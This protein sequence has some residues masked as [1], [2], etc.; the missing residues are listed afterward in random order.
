[1][2]YRDVR[3]V[4]EGAIGTRDWPNW[5][6]LVA[7]RVAMAPAVLHAVDD[8]LGRYRHCLVTGGE[9]RGKT[10]L[11]RYVG[12]RALT[13]FERPTY[14]ISV[15][16][17]TED[18]LAQLRDAIHELDDAQAAPLWIA[19]DLQDCDEP[20]ALARLVSAAC[21]TRHSLFLYTC[22]AAGKTSPLGHLDFVIEGRPVDHKQLDVQL[23]PDSTFI[24]SAVRHHWTSV[25]RTELVEPTQADADWVFSR[26]GGNLRAVSAHLDAWEHGRLA[27]VDE[28]AVL[29]R[30]YALRL[31]TLAAPARLQLVQM[32]AV[33]QFGVPVNGDL[34]GSAAQTDALVCD[35]LLVPT[36]LPRY[37][38][39][40]H[41]TDAALDCRAWAA[42]Y[43]T[44]PDILLKE[45]LIRYLSH[46]P[47]PEGARL[48]QARVQAARPDIYKLALSNTAVQQ[49]FVESHDFA[50]DSIAR[51]HLS[52]RLSK[53]VPALQHIFMM[54]IRARG[55]LFWSERF[56]ESADLDSAR[57]TLAAFRACDRA[58]ARNLE[59][60][61]GDEAWKA[62][63]LRTPL[64]VLAKF[65]WRYAEEPDVH[66]HTALARST[67]L[68][69]AQ[70]HDLPESV[71]LLS[72]E[73]VG[74]LLRVAKRLCGNDAV[75]LAQLV[76]S[77]T[78]LTEHANTEKIGL[79]LMELGEIGGAPPTPMT[80]F[81]ARVLAAMPL[82]EF[83]LD[84]RGRGLSFLMRSLAVATMDAPEWRGRAR[85]ALERV[86][87]AELPIQRWAPAALA[88]FLFGCAVIDSRR[89]ATWANAK[90]PTLVAMLGRAEDVHQQFL[91][92]WNVTQIDSSLGGIV[93]SLARPSL[94]RAVMGKPAC[95]DSLGLL[96]LMDY[97]HAPVEV[98][99]VA[100]EFE[101]LLRKTVAEGYAA[102]AVFALV[103]CARLRP[104]LIPSATQWLTVEPR[105]TEFEAA[106]A[107]HPLAAGAALLRQVRQSLE[108][109]ST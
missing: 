103:A 20:T 24:H 100:D 104:D 96:G 61:L 62:I 55:P 73:N 6:D 70:L 92:L 76:A 50:S 43:E 102:Q 63:W 75:G 48:L 16:E 46:Q 60:R 88:P 91:T 89:T 15:N 97:L 28:L 64:R 22:R 49:A 51:V 38:R 34:L 82:R 83:L 54:R 5:R 27:D 35:G 58:F 59:A 31:A 80:V 72:H 108:V 84:E 106:L 87:D 85:D 30:I 52:L 37:M 78:M 29:S 101:P 25:G 26:T 56:A 33:A 68:S 32:S 12:F 41:S 65:L 42:F 8:R 69:L 53:S 3:S 77:A 94:A 93:A 17:P 105:N 66:D 67:V 39:P 14:Q 40:A 45:V 36:G 19:E 71:S 44:D 23:A 74:K 57:A 13:E 4:L 95:A 81:L 107:R 18:S 90:S 109:S 98:P 86:L 79:I 9:G 2:D 47:R 1:M 21:Q 7:K 11:A 10:S 99:F